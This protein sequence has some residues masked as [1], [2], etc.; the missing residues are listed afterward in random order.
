M[1]CPFKVGDCIHEIRPFSANVAG[2]MILDGLWQLLDLAALPLD[3]TKPDA[4][5]TEITDKGFKYT[6][7]Y[8]IPFGR[9]AWGMMQDGGECYPEAYKFWRKTL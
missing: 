3:S 5:V 8:P 7:D 1:N 4:T 6:Y 2:P 9:A